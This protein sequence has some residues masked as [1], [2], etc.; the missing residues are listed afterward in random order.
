MQTQFNGCLVIV[1]HDRYFMDKLVDHLFVF[2]G[3][4]T[5]LDH[6]GN[7]TEYRLDAKERERAQN[8]SDKADKVAEK[9]GNTEGVVQQLRATDTERKEFKRLEKE[10][11]KLEKRKS[12]ITEQFNNPLKLTPKDIEKLGFELGDVQKQVEIKELRWLELSELV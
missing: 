4:G 7:Y 5:I 1:T 2:E 6:N 11:E 12:E 3:N 8:R 10:I 9:A